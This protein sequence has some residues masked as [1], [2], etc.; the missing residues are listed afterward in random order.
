MKEFEKEVNAMKKL[1]K[2]I[3]I[4]LSVTIMLLLQQG[5]FSNAWAAPLIDPEVLGSITLVRVIGERY[6]VEPPGY[7][8]SGAIVRVRL[9]ELIDPSRPNLI[10]NNTRNIQID[11]DDVVYYG[12]TNEQGTVVF[13]DLIQGLWLVEELQ[14]AVI[15]GLPRTSPIAS[16]RL[17]TPFLV[18]IPHVF[19]GEVTFAVHAV[20]KSELPPSPPPP[21]PPWPGNP[22]P[23]S[24][25]GPSTTPPGRIPNLP[26]T[27]IT[28][29][30]FTGIGAMSIS[31]AVMVVR[32]KRKN[33][34]YANYQ[35]S[36]H[37]N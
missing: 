31:L 19:N 33:I 26:Q 37:N 32:Q 16:N 15:D 5:L 22:G 9:V 8:V 2:I 10:A 13:A 28:M 17:F 34:N 35:N 21:A 4:A 30:T 20:P 36:L 23:G 11:G 7:L 29:M 14:A 1:K 25:G 3:N 27:G 12:L 18:G 24:P 6:P